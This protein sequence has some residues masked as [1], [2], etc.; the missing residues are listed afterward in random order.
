MI[1]RNN[2]S[3]LSLIFTIRGSVLER[4]RYRLFVVF[5]V[6]AAATAAFELGWLGA[7]TSLTPLPFT[8]VG[9]ALSIFLGFRNSASYDRYWEG[10]KLWGQLVN[11]SRSFTREVLTL[12]A[13]A[14]PG[15]EGAVGALRTELVHRHI[16]YV[17][18]LK[19]HL[20]ETWQLADLAGLLPS[21][22]LAALEGERNR[23][24]ALLQRQGERVAEAWRRGWI[25]PMHLPLLEQQLVEIAN[26]QGGCERI[27]NTPLPHAFIVLLHRIVS[28]YCFSLPF[29]IVETTHYL[30]PLVAVM[31]GYAFFGLDAIGDEIEEPFG[32]DRNDLPLSAIATN[33]EIVLRQ[34]LGEADLPDAPKPVDEVLT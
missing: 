29:G 31:V 18:A 27:H 10:R 19:M 28:A 4:I 3:W 7:H 25:H 14:S 20:R 22:E 15:D 32:L 26:V 30:T 21:A 24:N 16:A 13:P 33:I 1:V 2:N 5:G 11:T 12:V 23:P 8:L 34:R 9:F 17:H 6:A